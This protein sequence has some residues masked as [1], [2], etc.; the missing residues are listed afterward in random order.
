MAGNKPLVCKGFLE[1]KTFEQSKERLKLVLEWTDR[2]VEDRLEGLQWAF[3][4]DPDPDDVPLTRKIKGRNLWVAR[5][6]HP[7]LRV[8]M[9]PRAEVQDECELM[10]I[11][12]PD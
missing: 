8:Y 6:D 11:E 2:Q 12:E 7:Y 10:W 5:T 1:T 9:R 3:Q 4:H